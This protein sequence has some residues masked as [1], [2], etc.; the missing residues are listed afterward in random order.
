MRYRVRKVDA[1]GDTTREVIESRDGNV[2]RMVQ[3]NG[4]ALT[5]EED[6]AERDRLNE[7]LQSPEVFLRHHR[8]DKAGLGYATEL[9]QALPQAMIWTYTPGQPQLPL[10]SGTE[11]VLDYAPDPHFKPP[12]LVTEGLTAVAGRVWVDARSHCMVRIE[13]RILHP[14]DFGWGG[15][16]ARINGGGTIEFEQVP[17]GEQRWL[18]SHLDEHI[19]IREVMVR[20]INEDTRMSAWDPHPLPA[21]ISFQ[22]AIRELLAMPRSAN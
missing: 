2:A 11:V 3:R 18:F 6:A 22:D 19:A 17:A 15:M 20:T 10:S 9:I 8:R 14:V 5:G 4:S 12:T 16:L 21:S 1:K 13:G 7:I